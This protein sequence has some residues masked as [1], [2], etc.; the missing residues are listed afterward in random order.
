MK[1]KVVQHRELIPPITPFL[2][3]DLK[4]PGIGCNVTPAYGVG[5]RPS[6]RTPRQ[7]LMVAKARNYINIEF[8]EKKSGHLIT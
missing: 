2:E 8:C 3:E 1:T 4:L 5:P 7:K 6:F